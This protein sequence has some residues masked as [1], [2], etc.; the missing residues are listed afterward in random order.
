MGKLWTGLVVTQIAATVLF[1]AIAY[2]VHR[3]AEY[4][5]SVKPVFPISKYVS[6]RVEMES[7]ATAEEAAAVLARHRQSFAAAVRELERR[8]ASE[9]AVAGVTVG[10]QLPLMAVTTH[11]AIEVSG[12]SPAEPPSRA[13]VGTSGVAPNFFEV[14]QMPVLAGR[15]FDSRDLNE[16]ANTVVVNNL[17]VDRIL[18][19]RIA[20]GRRIRFQSVEP[21]DEPRSLVKR[22]PLSW[23]ERKDQSAVSGAHA[24]SYHRRCEPHAAASRHSP[25]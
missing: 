13:K 4:I 19:G 21:P 2:I 18:G 20:I 11:S 12:A 6:V 9:S 3:Q 24:A 1:T 17:F 23:R 5:A 8:L 22:S 25:A 7:E 15:T 10:E 14:F 16:N